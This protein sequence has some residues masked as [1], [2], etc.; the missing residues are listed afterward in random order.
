MRYADPRIWSIQVSLVFL[1]YFLL[2]LVVQ[3]ESNIQAERHQYRGQRV[4]LFRVGIQTGITGGMVSGS[5]LFSKYSFR[6]AIPRLDV[7]AS[8]QETESQQWII[9]PASQTMSLR[10]TRL[11]LPASPVPQFRCPQSRQGPTELTK[12]ATEA[13]KDITRTASE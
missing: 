3:R 13:P 11:R 7:S 5:L 6:V 12:R 2:Y 4:F 9:P 10:P 1:W 8:S